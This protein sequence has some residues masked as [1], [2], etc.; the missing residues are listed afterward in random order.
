[1]SDTPEIKTVF[2]IINNICN[3]RT[4]L[5]KE[6]IEGVY[7]P[8][9]VNKGMSYYQDTAFYAEEASRFPAS[10]P[11]YDQY[12]YYFNIVP[13]RKRFAPWAK[14]QSTTDDVLAIQDIFGVSTKVALSYIESIP[15]EEVQ[16]I[17]DLASRGG[18]MKQQRKGKANAEA[19][20]G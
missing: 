5:S 10:V 7:N 8:F 1:M 2:D 11:L 12:L 4:V 3:S 14:K 6:Q 18:K 19:S 16:K 9:M 13:K 20:S 17:I 15:Q